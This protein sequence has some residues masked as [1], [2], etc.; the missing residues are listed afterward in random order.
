MKEC[1]HF[2]P[3]STDDIVT[4]SRKISTPFYLI[5]EDKIKKNYNDM[6]SSLS[7][8]DN[9][10]IFYSIK[11]NYE[12]EVLRTMK[13]LGAGADV[14]CQL[15]LHIAQ[16]YG[17]D[18]RNIVIDNSYN[19]LEGLEE[20]ISNDIHMIN[21]ESWNEAERIN[22]L[23]QGE[24][25]IVNIGIRID[26][27]PIHRDIIRRPF[28]KRQRRFGIVLDE[29][30][31]TFAEKIT[32]LKNIRLRGL[33]THLGLPYPVPND[34]TASLR[35][36]FHLAHQFKKYGVE[37]D[38][39]NLGGGFPNPEIEYF[40]KIPILFRKLLLIDRLKKQITIDFFKEISKCYLEQSKKFNLKPALSLEPGKV[41][42]DN[43]AVIVGC[44]LSKY[45]NQIVTDISINDLGFHPPF[46]NRG[47][48][49]ANKIGEKPKYKMNIV[50]PTCHPFDILFRDVPTPYIEIGDIIIIFNVGG[51]CIARSIQHTRPR[52]P[53]YFIDSLGG[54]TLIRR[55]ETWE[56]V[57]CTQEYIKLT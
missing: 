6:M 20:A 52:R 26:L 12:T 42:V 3:I 8:I 31:D 36:L 53:V 14:S 35:K 44:V 18:Y 5:F 51:Y 19:I 55:E 38:E 49:I 24:K 29:V 4:L 23:A 47:F 50:G 7:R 22:L 21:I 2:N 57:I 40:T 13:D 9:V 30:I 43:A 16:K 34:Y 56:D 25:R 39:L 15:D 46:K 27:S 37:I 33:F 17:F 45:K 10:R 54:V 11:T 32:S 41:L 28:E 1:N 48:I